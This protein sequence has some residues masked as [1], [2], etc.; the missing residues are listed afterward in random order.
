MEFARFRAG[1]RAGVKGGLTNAI[2]DVDCSI[3]QPEPSEPTRDI[4]SEILFV[5]LHSSVS[6]T[7]WHLH[8]TTSQWV[9]YGALPDDR[10]RSREADNEYH[11]G[12]CAGTTGRTCPNWDDST[13]NRRL[14]S[15]GGMVGSVE[16]AGTMPG[17]QRQRRSREGG[18]GFQ[19]VTTVNTLHPQMP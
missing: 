13:D 3:L 14:A 18:E 11:G 2:I 5:H 1:T 4:L 7:V 8:P 12:T 17:G 9:T 15:G 10:R 19:G 6:A 16:D